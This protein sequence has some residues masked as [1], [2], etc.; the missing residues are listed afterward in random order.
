MNVVSREIFLACAASALLSACNQDRAY[1]GALGN[2]V[3]G[4]LHRDNACGKEDVERDLVGAVIPLRLEHPH[5]YAGRR[6]VCN[7][8]E[9]VI[10]LKGKGTPEQRMIDTSRGKV[11]VSYD[12]G[13]RYSV[14]DLQA[15]ATGEF[16]EQRFPGAR[17]VYTD[18]IYGRV[19]VLV[20]DPSKIRSSEDQARNVERELGLPIFVMAIGEAKAGTW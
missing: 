2:D 17:G 20:N 1:P 6:I 7:P 3:Q 19:I 16:L 12:A 10:L 18:S 15:I 11:A 4:Q 9:L 14:Q 8:L 5:R 13:Y